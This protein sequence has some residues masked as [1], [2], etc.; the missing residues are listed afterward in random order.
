MACVELPAGQ[1]LTSRV[2]GRS[3]P[4]VC[5][6]VGGC[7]GHGEQGG[8]PVTRV[9]RET[10][11]V[12]LGIKPGRGLRADVGVRP[13][14]PAGLRSVVLCASVPGPVSPPGG[15]FSFKATQSCPA[16]GS[17]H[18]SLDSIVDHL[19]RGALGAESIDKLGGLVPGSGRGSSRGRRVLRL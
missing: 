12:L 2:N 15:S 10:D 5:L 6:Q 13:E 14:L 8:P 1:S 18:P 3:G 16:P 19:I 4:W 9:L 7:G 11:P 17:Q